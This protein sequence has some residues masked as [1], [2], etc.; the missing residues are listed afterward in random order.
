MDNLFKMKRLSE[1]NEAEIVSDRKRQ[2]VIT[3]SDSKSDDGMISQ[4]L[5]VD[6]IDL[7]EITFIP[8]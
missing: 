2:K 6:P 8:R 5:T 7:N 1:A 3:S 4:F